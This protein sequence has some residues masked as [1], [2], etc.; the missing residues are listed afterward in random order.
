MRLNRAGRFIDVWRGNGWF[1]SFLM[2]NGYLLF[3]IRPTR[4]RLAKVRPPMKPGVVRFYVGPLEI[5]R[6]TRLLR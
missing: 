5:E 1:V 2:R 4:W 6:T 3:A